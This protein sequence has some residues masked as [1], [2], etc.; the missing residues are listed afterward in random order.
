[1]IKS[2]QRLPPSRRQFS[3]HRKKQF[4]ESRHNRS[5]EYRHRLNLYTTPPST[6]IPLESFEE[7]ALH[8]LKVLSELETC[9]FRNRTPE[10]TQQHM[11]P[12]L[13]QHMPLAQNSSRSAGLAEERRRDHY[14]HFILRLAFARTEELRRRFARLELQL[15][16]LRFG[17]NDAGDRREFV[18]GLRL[19]WE[20]VGVEERE[21]L[22]DQLSAVERQV[23]KAKSGDDGDGAGGSWFK[24]DWEKVPE[25][26]EGRKVLLRKGEAYVPAREQA[27]MVFA[28]F[29]RKLEEGLELTSR[30]LPRLDEDD[31]LAP[32]LTHLSQSFISPLSSYDDSDPSNTALGSTPTASSID[33]L[34][35]HFPL[36]M[37]HLHSNLRQNG[38]LKHF[39]RLQYTLFL[40]GLGLPLD[41]ALSFWRNSFVLNPRSGI[42]DDK[43]HKEYKYNVRHAYGDV[44]GDVNRRGRGYSPYSCQKLLTEALPGP[45]QDHGCPYR[46]FGAENL[47]GLLR[48]RGVGD[49]EVLK[50]VREDVGRLRYHVACNRVFEWSHRGEIKRVREEGTWGEGELDTIDHPNQYFKRSFMLKH[51]DLAK[52]EVKMEED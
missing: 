33:N 38:H 29:S 42:T 20:K 37:S 28:E 15:F 4:A 40:K 43:F 44:G 41:Q 11:T 52:K 17:T 22:K 30:A 6:D 24:V 34:A 3:D 35:L 50:G 27:S 9:S 13:Q 12:I 51:P 21:E 46:T 39:S 45:G 23:P 26:V 19:G 25:L 36:C 16:K 1:M 18:E 31:R 5:P 32:I 8:R 49:R 14:S 47:E 48:A 2:D 7:W 10:E